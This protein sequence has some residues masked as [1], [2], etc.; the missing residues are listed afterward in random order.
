MS[1][2]PASV[3]PLESRRLLSGSDPLITLNQ[4]VL[5]Y[6]L[7]IPPVSAPTTTSTGAGSGATTTP[8]S[9][10]S[11]ATNS[12]PTPPPTTTPTPTATP[13]PVTRSTNLVGHWTGQVKA[14]LFLFITK[15]FSAT[16]DISSQTATALTG[17]ISIDGNDFTGTFTGHISPK[18]GRFIYTVKDNDVSIKIT[19]RLNRKATA[20]YGDISAEFMGFS[21]KGRHEFKKAS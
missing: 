6:P 8:P 10:S 11:A 18:N 16:L 21:V 13:T 12:T 14:K 19:G 3:E 9:T 1:Y 5:S 7:L 2:P 17:T 4:P 15:K 20:M